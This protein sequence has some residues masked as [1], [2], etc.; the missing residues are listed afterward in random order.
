VLDKGSS[1]DLSSTLSSKSLV[2]ATGT[3]RG[4]GDVICTGER[5]LR[6]DDFGHSSTGPVFVYV[7]AIG[8]FGMGVDREEDF[9]KIFGAVAD[10]A[11]GTI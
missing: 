1:P 2:G 6:A 8:L 9:S 11:P 3:L 5:F 7:D 4:C 10:V